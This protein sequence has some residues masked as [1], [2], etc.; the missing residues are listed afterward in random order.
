MFLAKL[1]ITPYYRPFEKAPNAFD[2]VRT[3]VAANPLLRAMIDSVVLHATEIN[4][5]ECRCRVR[6]NALRLRAGS[7]AQEVT[8]RPSIHS[9]F[10][11]QTNRTTTLDCAHNAC[12][13]AFIAFAYASARAAVPRIIVFDGT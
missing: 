4:G 11:F 8:D 5:I 13:V 12:L 6:I 10:Y 1:M 7:L 9:P 3:N 2:T